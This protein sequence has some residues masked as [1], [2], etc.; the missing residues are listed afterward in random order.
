LKYVRIRTIYFFN[1]VSVAKMITIT[2]AEEGSFFKAI[3]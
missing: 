2:V 1:V 3:F